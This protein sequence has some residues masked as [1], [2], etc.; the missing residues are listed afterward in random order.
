MLRKRAIS[1]RCTFVALVLISLSGLI[2]AACEAPVGQ[3][4]SITGSVSVQPSGGSSW[5]TA[6]LETRLCEG[7]TIR[8]GERSRAAVSLINNAVLR[9]DQNTAMRLIDITPED[10]E[11]SLLDLIRGVFQSFSRKPKYL[12]VN[13]PYLNG[14]VEGTEFVFRA[15]NDEAVITV[16]EGVVIAS[17]AHG[18]VAIRRGE[19]AQGSKGQAP[20]R[21]VIVEPRDLVQWGLFY[22]PVLS[23]AAV[24]VESPAMDKAANCAANGNTSCAFSVLGEIPEAQRD[25]RYLLLRAATLLSV[26]R[27]EEARG[28]IDAALQRDAKASVAYALRAVIG[29]AQN[30]REAALA[31]ARRSVELDP[32]SAAAKVAL[33][34]ALQAN[35][36]LAAARDTLFLAVQQEPQNALAWARLAELHLTEG[37][38]RAAKAAAE[39]AVELQPGLSRT[40]N[41]L[42]FSALAEI[43]GAQAQAAFKRAIALDSADPLPRLGLGLA[44]IRQG[45]LDAGRADLEAAVA[46]DSNNALL[47]AYLGKA[48][49]EEKRGALDAKQ[50]G[51]AKEL[52]PLDPTAYFYNAIRLQTENR[53]VEALRDFQNAIDRNDN[54]LV[55]RSRLLLDKD[56]AA[57]GASL[58][59]VH[60]ALGFAQLGIN[61]SAR[62]LTLDPANASAHRFLSDT[63]RNG[64][65]QEAARVSELLQSQMLQDI[66]I[67]PV[68][69]SMSS[70]NLNIVARGGPAST[71]F[72][73]FTPLF[74]R[75]QAQFNATGG[76]G[77][78]ETLS[79]EAVLS[80]I[81]DRFSLSAGRFTYDTDGFRLNNDLKHE[82]YDLYAQVAVSPIVNLQAEFG[83]RHTRRGDLAMKFDPGD[84][85]PTFRRSLDADIWRLGARITPSPSSNILLSVIN[86]DRDIEG[87]ETEELFKI[88]GQGSIDL[89]I[90]SESHDETDQYEAQYLFQAVGFNAI[91]GG[92][93]VDVDR[94]D[95][96]FF[97]EES[98][99]GTNPLSSFGEEFDINDGR[100]YAYG[101]FTLGEGMIWTLGLSYQTYKEGDVFDFDKTSP[102]L[103]LQWDLTD[104][105]LLRGAYFEGVKPVLSSNRTLEPTQ[106]AGFNQY[107]DDANATKFKRYGVGADWKLNQDLSFGAELTRRELESPVVSILTGDGVFE[108]RDE[109]TNRVYGFWTPDERWSLSAEFVYDK[110]RNQRASDLA[111]DVPESVRTLSFPLV[112]RYFHPNGFFASIGATYVDQ[113]VKG[114]PT[115]VYKTGDSGFTVVDLGVGYRLPKR[116]GVVSLAIQ[117]LFDK[118]FDYLDNSY[119]TY[120]DEPAVSPYTPS[121]TIMGRLTL[122]F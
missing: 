109:W 75:N 56:R 104:A 1:G 40:Q 33:S 106:V 13:T 26:G 121:R 32:R 76:G 24:A 103:G 39:R 88:P 99:F 53:P 110:F 4:V 100:A 71:G 7:D 2:H 57:R 47:R 97:V 36:E 77:S 10:D 85:D 41:V 78:N 108:D 31:D 49:F 59:R 21:R 17:N 90:D 83:R 54:R 52:D 114:D 84:F 35:L 15:T 63:H 23:T 22:P 101:N 72:N 65:R 60:N 51:V 29:V 111:S 105:L 8:V 86:A 20:Q 74:E 5:S 67:N 79:S 107:F 46:L 102:K 42:G 27:V 113:R 95:A 94:K 3:F 11:S 122:S 28:D 48:Y 98:P 120:R 68:Q 82:I 91:L 34:Y 115:Y 62:A 50:Y 117:N 61:E 16:L 12:R 44:K 69:P 80:G 55:Y 87:T 38:R 30:D 70:T 96:L 66:N 118:E 64:S 19:S 93:Y 6:E 25:A 37:N 116:M 92:S 73:E 18:E 9:I 89:R 45:H 112:A 43:R 119:R 81:Y 14:S 58:A